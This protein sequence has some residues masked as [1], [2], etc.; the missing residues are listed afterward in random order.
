MNEIDAA[1]I[2][3]DDK[4]AR[5]RLSN[6]ALAGRLG[7]DEKTIRRHRR[8]MRKVAE[9]T[10]DKF[11]T[12][13][14]LSRITRRG[15]TRRLP[16]GS[17][18]KIEF[19]PQL[20]D[21]EE[22]RRLTYAE[23]DKVFSAPLPV[24]AVEPQRA[25]TLVVTLADPQMGKTDALGGSEET[26]RRCVAAMQQAAEHARSRGGYE[27]II[28][29]DMGDAI[30]GFGNVTSQQQT[31]DLSLVDQIRAVTR[32]YL[33][34]LKMFAPLCRRL[35]QVSVPS[36]HCAVRTG[37]GSKNRSNAPDDD[38]GIL[39]QDTLMHA[40]SGREGFEHVQ[41]ARPEKWEEAITVQT[42]D[43]TCV[44]FTHGHMAGSQSKMPGWFRDLAFGHR[45]GLH[46]A[47]VLVHGHFHNFGVSMVGDDRFIVS[48]PT[49]DNG[50]SWFANRS[51]N[52]TRP[53]LL[54]F[55]VLSG[56]PRD[57]VLHYGDRTRAGAEA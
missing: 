11:F 48:C 19:N 40:V 15:I 12:D 7:C 43:G 34:A 38:Y 6:R 50:S 22:A 13:V 53:A 2:E 24:S 45:S 56:R 14:P 23:L 8:A 35:V 47:H 55:E 39:I 30:E 46:E 5:E 18:E 17:Y 33:E 27:E 41:F 42:G 3:N 20:L 51:G 31:N 26:I 49:L 32:L 54:S 10:H 4:P 29:A 1:I 57:W 28:L 25:G 21:V 36:N 44:G 52:T 16:D 37:T 9:R